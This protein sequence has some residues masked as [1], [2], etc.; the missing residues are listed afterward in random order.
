MFSVSYRTSTGPPN[1]S[2]LLYYGAHHLQTSSVLAPVA[3]AGLSDSKFKL[4]SFDTNA[5]V[6]NKNTGSSCLKDVPK[7]SLG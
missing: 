2:A 7:S 6:Q 5:D 4:C 1:I 3:A